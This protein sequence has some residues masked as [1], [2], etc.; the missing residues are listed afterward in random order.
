MRARIL[1]PIALLGFV[2]TSLT[3]CSTIQGILEGPVLQDFEVGQCLDTDGVVSGDAT[4]TGTIPVVDCTEAHDAEVYY[5][6]ETTDTEFDEDALYDEVKQ[7]CDDEFEDYVGVAYVDSSI[8]IS[9]MFPTQDSWDVD[10]RQ[11]VCLLTVDE[12]VTQSFAG[13]GL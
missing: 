12:D 1:A 3:G 4:Q 7:A 11:L 9:T 10:D 8:Y 2:T 6:S 13:S 5:V